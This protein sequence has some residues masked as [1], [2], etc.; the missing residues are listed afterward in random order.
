[1][2]LPEKVLLCMSRL[3]EAG[4]S[5]YAV[6]GCTR[7]FLL[8]L[9][10]HDYDLC[11]GAD[12]EQMHRIFA[13]YPL[14]TSGE[15]HG[16]VG[17]VI[18]GEP[19]E[20]TTY[21]AEGGYQDHR[22]PDFIRFVPDVEAD[23]SRRDFTVNAIAYCPDEGFLDPFGGQADLENRILRTVGDP[24]A[25]FRE[26]ALRILRGV[27]FAVKYRLTP[28]EKTLSAMF[29]LTPLLDFLARERVFDELCK[30]LLL[31]RAEDLIFYAPILTRVLPE[32]APCVGF[33]Q[34]SP[35]HAYDVYVHTAHVTENVPATLPL[36]WAAL[37]HDVG[38]PPCY[39]ADE[40]GRGHFYGHGEES[41]RLAR[42]TLSRLRAPNALRERVVFLVAHHMLPLEPEKKLLRR[43]LGQYGEEAL[44]E[45]LALQKAD[46]SSKG[47][48][49]D[50]P[51]DFLRTE[52]LI[53]EIL[54]EGAC[55]TLKDL[56]V[57][58]SDLI[59][60]GYAPGREIGDCLRFLLEQVQSDALPNE[61][62]ALLDR[63]AGWKQARSRK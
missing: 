11:T 4:F 17:V 31:A 58:G 61:R 10:P 54:A 34:H 42:Q 25:R 37:L 3:K 14:V 8:G 63:A 48:G 59:G 47:T 40:T 50:E 2:V 27:R 51:S 52:A 49:M 26:D 62:P 45:L 13:D 9:S 1:M 16:T 55:L 22:H 29:A 57:S 44:W 32:L 6:G 46:F 60:I 43:R 23:L 7:D 28:E 33:D 39:T 19:V 41:A 35:H 36:R 21:R 18:G 20:I 38:K 53:R 24:E 56:A 30:L 12:P 5:A 15:K